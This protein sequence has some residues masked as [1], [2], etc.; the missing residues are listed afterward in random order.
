MLLSESVEHAQAEGRSMSH[1]IK[2]QHLIAT[3]VGKT[4]EPFL[5]FTEP[6]YQL[7]IQN[8]LLK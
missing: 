2:I 1:N 6:S 5:T 7:E 3:N 4:F 8:F